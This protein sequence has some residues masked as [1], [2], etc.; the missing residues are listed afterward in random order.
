M[1]KKLLLSTL[2]LAMSV[3][4]LTGCGSAD[5][6]DSQ[7]SIAESLVR[8]TDETKAFPFETEDT[9]LANPWT[10][11]DRD[12][13]SAA[14]GFTIAAPEGAAD[15]SYSYMQSEGM[16]QVSYTLD[17][18]IWNYRMQFADEL[19]DISGMEYDWTGETDG[20]VSGLTAKYYSFIGSDEDVQVVNWYDSVSGIIYS[21]SATS[22]D[23]DGMDIQTYAENL[24]APQ[25]GD[26]TDDPA[27][28]RQNELDSFFLGEHTKSYDG[29]TL[30]IA[31]NGDGTFRVDISIV[32]LCYLENGTGTFED[33]KMY[34]EVTDPAEGTM[35]GMIYL[36]SDTSLCVKITDSTW[37]LLPTDEVIDGFGK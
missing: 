19:T 32:G 8:E 23:L 28:D 13:V 16:A 31:D 17:S 10:V 22:E 11:S 25:S 20:T 5:E 12:S 26:A 30:T 29:S 18:I 35:K 2:L 7:I 3:A 9:Q 27:G 21:L 14:T 37:N 6:E 4:V 1:K 34:F 36:D 33:H 15:V 24:Y